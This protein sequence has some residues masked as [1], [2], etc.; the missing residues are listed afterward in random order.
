M[1]R[2]WRDARSIGDLGGAMAGW[3][4]GRIAAHPGCSVG[5]DEETLPLVTVLA[6]LNRRGYVTTMSQPGHGGVA[7]DG[8]PWVQ[9]ACVEGLISVHD[10]ML[11]RIIRAAR[12][13]GLAVTAYGAGRSVGPA[14]G[15]AAT[16]WGVRR[17]PVSEAVHGAYGALRSCS[18]SDAWPAGNWYATASCWPS[19]TPSGAVT[20]CCG[21]C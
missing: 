4:E 7:D 8:R 14:R 12:A 17:T 3:L 19:W 9:R 16:R 18:A 20:T 21:R 11:P 13:A 6:R 10:P 15:L 2:I 5:P 1:D